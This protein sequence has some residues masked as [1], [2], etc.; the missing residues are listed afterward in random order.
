MYSPSIQD[1]R[2]EIAVDRACQQ[3][4]VKLAVD[5][6]PIGRKYLWLDPRIDSNKNKKIKDRTGYK[7]TQGSDDAIRI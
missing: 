3:R 6:E 1:R 7:H 5:C 4:L 2:Y